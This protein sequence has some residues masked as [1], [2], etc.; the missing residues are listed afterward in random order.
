MNVLAED[1]ATGFCIR[2]RITV[3]EKKGIAS[4]NA[5]ATMSQ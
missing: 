3:I 4:L 1:L 5:Y 2:C